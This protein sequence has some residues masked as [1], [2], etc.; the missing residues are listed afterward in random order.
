MTVAYGKKRIPLANLEER[1]LHRWEK[2]AEQQRGAVAGELRRRGFRSK[3]SDAAA[4]VDFCSAELKKKGC[5]VSEISETAMKLVEDILDEGGIGGNHTVYELVV[6]KIDAGSWQEKGLLK[7]L[8]Y[9]VGRDGLDINQRRRI[10]RDAYRVSLVPGSEEVVD[11]LRSWGSPLSQQRL[12][13]I[14]GS[15]SRFMGLAQNQKADYS[16]A[17][18]DWQ[19]DLDWLRA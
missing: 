17:L 10:L 3:E 2:L 18:A 16:A 4:L 5:R 13:M 12:N 1:I 6:D 15:I 11:Y 14:T 8:G 7:M 9:G 19:A